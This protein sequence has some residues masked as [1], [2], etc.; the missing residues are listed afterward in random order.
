VLRYDPSF[1]DACLYGNF[2]SA[3]KL[4]RQGANINAVFGQGETALV[5][6]VKNGDKKMATW[7]L[8]NGADANLLYGNNPLY[9]AVEQAST[10]LVAL[11]LEH[12]ADV[13]RRT[14][15]D[16][17]PLLRAAFAGHTEI[18]RQ[19]LAYGAKVNSSR[20]IHGELAL[21]LHMALKAG[22]DE[23]ARLLIESGSV[24]TMDK[25]LKRTLLLAAVTGSCQR[26]LEMLLERGDLILEARGAYGLTALDNAVQK[27]D[28]SMAGSLLRKGAINNKAFYDKRVSDMNGRFPYNVPEHLRS[29]RAVVISTIEGYQRLADLTEGQGAA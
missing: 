28:L 12:G 26:S 10:D 27:D 1:Y 13:E 22:H 20:I 4:L 14:A 15:S 16:S 19:L 11:L 3:Q 5:R 23:T 8:S 18:A 25:D 6:A 24:N 21:S 7:L 2:T 29:E 17:S 9:W